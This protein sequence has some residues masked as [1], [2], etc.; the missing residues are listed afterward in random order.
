M[1]LESFSTGHFG[2][3]ATPLRDLGAAEYTLVTVVVDDSGSV[4]S[5]VREMEQALDKI[6]EACKLCPESDNLMIRVVKF[7]NRVTEVHGFKL[8]PDIQSYSGVLGGHGLTA[9]YEATLNSLV[10][11]NTYG[12]TLSDQDYTVNGLLVVLTDGCNNINS[13]TLDNIKREMEKSVSGEQIESLLSILVGVDSGEANL[14]SELQR[15]QVECNFTQFEW[16]TDLS[17]KSLARFAQFVSKSASSQSKMI[18][19]GSPSQSLTF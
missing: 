6:V 15:M 18:G 3:S 16:M 7:N 9:L 2:F 13:A 11:M 17:A 8:L 19:T 14:K 10:A 4:N 5:K 1:S 12:K